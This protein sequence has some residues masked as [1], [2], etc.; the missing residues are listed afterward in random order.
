[1]S[2]DMQDYRG[3][4]RE[5]SETEDIGEAR[6]LCG[7]FLKMTESAISALPASRGPEEFLLALLQDTHQEPEEIEKLWQRIFGRGCRDYL[8]AVIASEER[9]D[10]SEVLRAFPDTW[11]FT[12]LD[13]MVLVT[14]DPANSVNTTEFRTLLQKHRFSAGLSRPFESISSF[15]GAYEEAASTLRFLRILRPGQTMACYDDF[16]M[17]RLLDSLRGDVDPDEFCLPDIRQLQSY[18]RTHGTELCRTLLCYLEHAKNVAGTATELNIHRNTVHYR[19]N[20][21]MELLK[22]LDFSNDYMAFLLLLSLYIIEHE[23]YRTKRA[24]AQG[25]L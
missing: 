12:W 22:D 1:M 21:S 25:L 15:P 9:K 16:L 8:A 6:R 24:Q 3:I 7:R 18:D 20:K 4:L 2:Q 11:V 23:D 17:L 19:V 14:G 5:I 10:C 13:R